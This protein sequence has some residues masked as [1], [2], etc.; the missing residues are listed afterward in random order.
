MLTKI[1]YG[2]FRSKRKDARDEEHE[3]NL[4]LLDHTDRAPFC[5][6]IRKES[7][8]PAKLRLCTMSLRLLSPAEQSSPRQY[9]DRQGRNDT[10]EDKKDKNTKVQ[11]LRR[12]ESK[13]W[14]RCNWFEYRP[15]DLL[16]GHGPN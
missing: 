16:L 6:A 8:E 13:G 14:F 1:M 15:F 9:S 11:N 2:V 3:Q 7:S 5:E 12:T 4:T 10:K